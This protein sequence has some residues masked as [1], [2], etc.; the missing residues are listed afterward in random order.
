MKR[1]IKIEETIRSFFNTLNEAS[2]Y[3]DFKK[4][5]KYCQITWRVRTS[6]PEDFLY[7]IFSDLKFDKILEIECTQDLGCLKRYRVKLSN[8]KQIF[9]INDLTVIGEKEEYKP[10]NNGFFGIN[11]ISVANCLKTI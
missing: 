7:S 9:R 6:I 8:K 10:D 2:G 3:D 4:A 1:H 11:P 5:V